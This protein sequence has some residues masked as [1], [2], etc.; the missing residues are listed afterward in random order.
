[1]NGK[2]R[3]DECLRTLA[4][5]SPESLRMFA[6]GLALGDG[7]FRVLA[8]AVDLYGDVLE[9][10]VEGEL[11]NLAMRRAVRL[12]SYNATIAER[13]EGVSEPF[14]QAVRRRADVSA[15]LLMP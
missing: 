12:L 2:L 5:A 8:N 1:M 10:D 4:G 11:A 13:L 14:W 7:P 9:H 15:N 6:S 3:A